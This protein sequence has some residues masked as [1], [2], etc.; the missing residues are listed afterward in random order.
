LSAVDAPG[1]RRLGIWTA[2][3][4]LGALLLH[5]L[6]TRAP[7]VDG[8][9]YLSALH[10][11]YVDGDVDLTNE[12]QVFPWLTWYSERVEPPPGGLRNPFP[13]GPALLWAPFYLAY[14]ALSH[15][16]GGPGIS[17]ETGPVHLPVYLGSSFWACLGLFVL[18]DALRMLGAS[19]REGWAVTAVVALASPLPAYVVFAPDMAHACAFACVSILL[20][21]SLWCWRKAA[22][23]DPRWMLC[24]L[25]LG[26]TFAVRW[27]DALL[28]V[29]P[30]CLMAFPRERGA[31]P[32]F[33][34]ER[35]RGLLLFG[36]GGLLGALPQ[37]LY[38]K[39]LYDSWIT[40][41]MGAGF[42]SLSHAEPLAFFFSTWNGLFLS[43]PALLIC[44]LGFALPWREGG[45]AAGRE[46]AVLRWAGLLAIGL[47]LFSCMLVEDWWAGGAFGQRRIVSLLPLL[48]LGLL[49]LQRLVWSE[50]SQLQRRLLAGSLALLVGWNGLSLVR[51]LD[52][53]LPYNPAHRLWY[54]DRDVYGHYEWGRRF[55]DIAFGKQKPLPP[56]HPLRQSA[57]EAETTP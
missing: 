19:R 2:A 32:L 40:M 21:T 7:Y 6:Q 24:G 16:A 49:R 18:A 10:S 12:S 35:L 55:S 53:S 3:A 45:D 34:P 38:W 11:L 41:P 48:A 23:G 8:Q 37:L 28:G 39:A 9:F 46:V 54:W 29:I 43:H 36:F 47:E 31:V 57:G 5:P 52:G 4:L 17:S 33:T 56:K 20:W 13:I 14:D 25:A 30:L 15:L 44:L 26:V 51:L 22:G 50:G 1:W 42:M 27:Q